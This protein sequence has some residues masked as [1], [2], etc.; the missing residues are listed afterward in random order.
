MIKRNEE[1]YKQ[2]N[3]A[4]RI[5]LKF[6][7]FRPSI[8]DKMVNAENHLQ[9]QLVKDVYTE[10]DI[11]GL[12]KNY[13]LEANRIKAIDTYNYFIRYY[14]L[15][16]MFRYLLAN[17][18]H[19]VNLDEILH[20]ATDGEEWEHARNLFL[21]R[22]EFSS[23]HEAGMTL[24]EIKNAIARQIFESKQRDDVRGEKITKGYNE[25]H[26]LAKD[27]EFVKT[28]MDQTRVY[29]KQIQNYL[30]SLRVGT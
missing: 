3:R 7:I 22:L 13:L 29:E 20:K 11:D 9:V 12:G 4:K 30:Q 16:L 23:L 21:S 10:S 19:E 8:V 6:S 26:V 15:N 5:H 14:C 18:T 28:T 27:N 25:A 2:R 24:I 17:T 1:K